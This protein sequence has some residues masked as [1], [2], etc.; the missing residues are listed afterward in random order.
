MAVLTLW[1]VAAAAAGSDLIEMREGPDPNPIKMVQKE[2]HIATLL[3]NI[4]G[5]VIT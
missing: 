1:D 3:K 4:R 5:T 2:Q